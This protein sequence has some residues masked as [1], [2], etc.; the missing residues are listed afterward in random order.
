MGRVDAQQ[1][2]Q[3]FTL[4][5][6]GQQLLAESTAQLQVG[7]SIRAEVVALT[8]QLQLQLLPIDTITPRISTGVHLLS[9]QQEIATQLSVLDEQIQHQPSTLSSETRQALQTLSS[10]LMALPVVSSPLPPVAPLITHGLA[11]LR[12]NSEALPT[13]Q[14]QE[15]AT[16]VRQL[17]DILPQP[18]S[19][20]AAM[21][22]ERLAQDR[23]WPNLGIAATVM[24]ATPSPAGTIPSWE[25]LTRHLEQF[26][27]GLQTLL[28]QLPHATQ[29]PPDTPGGRLVQQL[30]NW[31][32]NLP[33]SEMSSQVA[34][35]LSTQLQQT[36]P[37]LG[38]H[39]EQLLA[40]EKTQAA[41]QTA[42]F[43]L[44]EFTQQSRIDDNSAAQAHSLLKSIE[45]YQLLQIRL[46]TEGTQFLPLPFSFLQQGFVLIDADSGKQASNPHESDT[47]K[48][49]RL[50]LHL[51]LEGLG[52]LRVDI[53]QQGEAISLR[54]QA[55]NLERAQFIGHHRQ[56]L[57]QWLTSG[58]LQSVQF[59]AGAE[60]PIKTLLKQVVQGA[61]GMVN[62]K[63]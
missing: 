60:E 46:A 48:T 12:S 27:P 54:F 32:A 44:M 49:S 42:K 21:L 26:L 35:Q 40:Q 63:A 58:K 37:L 11:I 53:Q 50:S 16:L 57:E 5:V 6:Q 2:P 61:T 7:Q 4:T 20:Q 41:T 9:L 1:A 47:S 17:A 3:Q 18:Q 62:T 56:D 33:A 43:A 23:P 34:P 19:K 15:M 8:P 24:P 29:Q 10:N 38:L 22:A 36:T 14:L 59:L 31:L 30:F 28:Q 55:E 25:E 51:Q 52:N 39:L 45:L 13:Q